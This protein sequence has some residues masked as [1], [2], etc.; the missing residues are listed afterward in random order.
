MNEGQLP[1]LIAMMIV[2]VGVIGGLS[3]ICGSYM[4]RRDEIDG[5]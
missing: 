1:L 5:D 3:Y 4:N 2:A